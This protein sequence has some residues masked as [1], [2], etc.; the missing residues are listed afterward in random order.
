[1][2]RS[3]FILLVSVFSLGARADHITGGEMFYKY[4]GISGGTHH[5]SVTLKLYM[6]CNSGRQFPDPAI[7]SVFDKSTY[8]RI[9]DISIAMASRSTIQMNSFDPCITNPPTVCY[10]I[11]YYYFEVYVPPSAS[12]YILSSQ[13]NYRIRGM[14]N[15]SPNQ[16]VGATYVCEIPGMT[17]P[18]DAQVNNSAFFTGSDLVV[19]C[20]GN[21]FSYSFAASDADNNNLRYSFCAAYSTSNSNTSGT[22]ASTPPYFSIP[23]ADN[24]SEAAPLG[25]NVSVNSTTGMITGIA[26]DPG[27]YVVTV[28]AEEIKDGVVIAVQR[29]DIQINVADCNIAAAVL[30]SDYMLC[31]N[32]RSI[33]ISNKSTSPLIVSHDWEVFNPAGNSIFTANTRDLNFTFPV[34]GKYT[35]RLVINKGQQC[36]DTT[37]TLVY[38]FPGL[39]PDFGSSG[40][41]ITR[42]IN[43]TDRTTLISG[44]VNSW[45]WD[46]G[47]LSA[48]NDTSSTRNPGY[49]YPFIGAK[50]V[51]LIVTTTDGCRDTI[52]KIIQI[53][54]KP[55]I[56]LAF[57]D[58]L[59]C[60]NDVV[61]LQASGT[62]NFSW[63][64]TTNMINAAT[65]TPT[66]SP[67][68][69]TMY[70]V[71]LVTDGCFNRDSVRVRVVDHVS[72]QMMTDTT[73]CRGDTIQLR[74]V[75]D[76]LQYVWQPSPQVLTPG[77]ANPFVV[78][79]AS[80]PYQV[81]A[82]IGG[83]S[84]NGTVRVNTVPYPIANA[85]IDTI[86]CFNTSAQLH[87]STDGSSWQWSPASTLSNPAL[88]DPVAYPGAYLNHYILS[89]YDTRGC[90]KPGRD[91]VLVT[92]LPRIRPFAG[93][94]TVV[95]IN[96]P[97]Q[98]QAS[99]GD[100][101]IWTPAFSLSS[102]TLSNPVA[103]F[104]EPSNGIRYKVQVFNIA[105]CSDSA[106]FTVKVFATLPTVFVPT[107]FTPNNDGKNDILRP[108]AVGMKKIEYFSIFNRWGQLVFRTSSDGHGWDGSIGGQIQGTNT[109]VW[110]VK[111]IDFLGKPYFQK[112]MVTLIR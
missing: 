7:I 3:F 10:E 86:I 29:K 54:E 32:T 104:S 83:C 13:V 92:M 12:G 52:N 43:F 75:S 58:T 48:T 19:V 9:E 79:A 100:S 84:T 96:Q 95:V 5:Y 108:V 60:V 55:P 81:T 68:V 51:R 103:T 47:E 102:P 93:R 1:M 76:G 16:Q 27:M 66:V 24:Y 39:V 70:Y 26:P 67:P 38:V 41:C 106:F 97:L 85:G 53:I 101:Y 77:F 98:L 64:P 111:A 8:N 112:G 11:A 110:M 31:G 69:T 14:N 50:D 15:V 46:F 94:D 42:P 17:P 71:D 63:S 23:Y 57:R 2:K 88:L 34:N 25:G 33:T 109:Y 21:F 65:A 49:H 37:S 40:I 62:G 59:I 18:P 72:L 74:V 35:V 78:T 45:K 6:R 56:T 44:S 87:G 4:V 82:I 61:Q 20:A 107:G 91:T 80:T 28:C 99:G 89:A 90:P 30:N 22:P 36:S 73:I 105:G